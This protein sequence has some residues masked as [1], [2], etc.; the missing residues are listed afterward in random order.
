MRFLTLLSLVFVLAGC[1]SSNPQG[2]LRV[3]TNNIRHGEDVDEIIDLARIAVVISESH[4]DA[5]ALQ[6][7]DVKTART[8]WVDQVATLARLTGLEYHAFGAF[9]EYDG[10]QYGMAILSRHPIE[11]SRVIDLPPGRHEPRTSLLASIARPGAPFVLVGVHF[12]W[13]D[14][15]GA[16]FAQAKALVGALASEVRPLVIAGDFNDV[17]GSRTIEHLDRAWTRIPKARGAAA[18]FPAHQPEREI[19]MVYAWGSVTPPTGLALV[20]DEQDASDH[21]PVLATITW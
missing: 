19:D 15:D 17:P 21:R 16:R 2:P 11:S 3:M 7:I 9:M 1:V 12:D 4:P 18:T 6:E 13:L 8:G 5:V 14:D 20:I 10:G